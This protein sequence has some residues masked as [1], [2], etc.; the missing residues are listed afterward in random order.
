MWLEAESGTCHVL[1]VMISIV[2]D[3]TFAGEGIAQLLQSLGY[4][5]ALFPSAEQFL[6]S[7]RVAKTTC[8]I[9]DLQMPG[10]SGLDLQSRL[11]ADG[12]ETPII[13]ITAYPEERFRIC[14]L[15]GGA[16]GF[17]SKPLKEQ[18]LVECVNSAVESLCH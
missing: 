11:R 8:L 3:D 18:P 15:N 6:E 4:R 10:M 2:D 9:T 17:L 1:G 5:T 13:F 16:V 7:G 12:Y 14:A